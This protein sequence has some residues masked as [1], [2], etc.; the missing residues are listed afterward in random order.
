MTIEAELLR[1][2]DTH[3]DSMA[4]RLIYADYLAEHC[5]PR[6]AVWRWLA[7]GRQPT[8]NMFGEWGWDVGVVGWG[9]C[10]SLVFW[11]N[12]DRSLWLNS[13]LDAV[14]T[15]VLWQTEQENANG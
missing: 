12:R 6:E 2:I 15:F 8:Q 14:D 1:Q 7:E 3:R 13:L 4:P 5:D 10:L 11:K 9:A